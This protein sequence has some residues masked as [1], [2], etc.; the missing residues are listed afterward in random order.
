MLYAN[1]ITVIRC[2]CLHV[3]LSRVKMAKQITYLAPPS[4]FSYSKECGKILT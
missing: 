1:D 3:H 4:Y 2:F